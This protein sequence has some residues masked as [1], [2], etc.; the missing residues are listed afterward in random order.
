VLVGWGRAQGCQMFCFQ[1]K[2]PNLDKFW[3]VLQWLM[4][5]YFMTVWSILRPL[6]IFDGHLEY[7]IIFFPVLVCCTKRNLA[8]LVEL[9]LKKVS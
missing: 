9:W 2:N 5:E 8:T 4:L 7:F 3:R 6:E 1:T